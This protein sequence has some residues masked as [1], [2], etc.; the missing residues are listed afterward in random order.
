MIR[1]LFALLLALPVAAADFEIG[2]RHVVAIPTGDSGDL[3]LPL[4]RGFAAT[5]EFFFT[6]RV[7]AQASA[8]FVNPEAILFPSAPPPNDVDLGTLGLD[9]YSATA[10]VHFAPERR[11]S[12]F[13][14][15]GAA[16]VILGDLDDQ[17]GDEV[18]AE[19]DNELTLVVEGGLR[20]RFRPRV[21][22]D[23][24]ASYLPLE[25]QPKITR[26][27]YALPETMGIDPLIVS[28]GVAWRF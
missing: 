16:L 7:S 26:S 15:G 14:G 25:A 4:S 5:G 8:L 28:V 9:V 23:L 21:F 2:V 11:L 10:R 3:D 22:F 17:F 13:A 18:E 1:V 6:P 24:S 20:Y 27:A 12:A 19:F